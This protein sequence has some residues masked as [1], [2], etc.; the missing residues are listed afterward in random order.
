MT[1]SHRAYRTAQQRAADIKRFVDMYQNQ[2]LSL[3]DIADQVGLSYATVHRDLAAAGVEMRGRG[4]SNTR[5]TP[6]QTARSDR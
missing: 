4:G 5:K 6:P 3:Q 2:K 1:G